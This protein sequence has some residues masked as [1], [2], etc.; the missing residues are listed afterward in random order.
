MSM[1]VSRPDDLPVG[2][3]EI[4]GLE[5]D[6]P[7]FVLRGNDATAVPLLNLYSTLVEG[8]Y[9]DTA[10][11]SE[12]AESLERLRQKFVDYQRAHRDRVKLPD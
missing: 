2:S 5:E 8:M 12:K 7:I 10:D 6:E 1:T 11:G 4:D 9:P 3:V